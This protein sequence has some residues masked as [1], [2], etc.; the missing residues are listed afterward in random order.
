[1]TYGMEM[2]FCQKSNAVYPVAA[3]YSRDSRRSAVPQMTHTSWSAISATNFAQPAAALRD[4]R[5]RRRPLRLRRPR[6][7]LRAQPR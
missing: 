6:R 4:L 7:R 1:M 2:G 5:R 3:K